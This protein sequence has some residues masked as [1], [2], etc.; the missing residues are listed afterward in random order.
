ML[1]DSISLGEKYNI[2]LKYYIQTV[3]EE[4]RAEW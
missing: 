3:K 1:Y 2:I 4:H